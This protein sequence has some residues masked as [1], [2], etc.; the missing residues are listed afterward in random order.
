MPVTHKKQEA[1]EIIE[2]SVFGKSKKDK[3]K[4]M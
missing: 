1:M 4:D 3:K 2:E